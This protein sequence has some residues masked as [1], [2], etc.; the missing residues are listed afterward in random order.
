MTIT[1]YHGLKA[2]GESVNT[3]ARNSSFGYLVALAFKTARHVRNKE[4]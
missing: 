1:A 4:Y 3:V 2:I